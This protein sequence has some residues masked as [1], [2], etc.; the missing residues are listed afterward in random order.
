[1]L[2][3][4]VATS[5]VN[6]PI[7]SS[8]PA[9]SGSGRG[10]A[11]IID[12]PEP[13]LDDDRVP[14]A[15]RMPGSRTD[16]GDVALARAW[17]SMRAGRAVRR[18]VEVRPWSPGVRCVPTGTAASGSPQLATDLHVA[19]VLVADDPDRLDVQES[20]HLLRDRGEDRGG[21]RLAR[22]QR[23]HAP[24]RGLLVGEALHLRARSGRSRSRW[25]R[26]R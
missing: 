16:D 3:I 2:E 12:S 23:R 15:E 24:Q 25:R 13:S 7:R 18:T 26:A 21:R 8:V 14:T 9:G 10:E 11:A 6:S 22:D 4:E 1:M 17:S 20:P 5:S 19:P